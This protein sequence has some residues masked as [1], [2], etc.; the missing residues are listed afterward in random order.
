MKTKI[1]I[2]EQHSLLPTQIALLPQEYEIVPVPAA[3]WD[4]DTIKAKSEEWGDQLVILVSPIPALMSI[5]AK[6]GLPFQ[7][8]HNDKRE[9]KEL[10]NG[11]I[12]HAV[13]KEGWELV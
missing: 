2:N 8:F 4:L 1:V 13:A 9:K 3:G 6:S 5:R 11:K 7:V 12:I 10:P